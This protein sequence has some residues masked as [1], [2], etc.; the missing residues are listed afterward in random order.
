MDECWRHNRLTLRLCDL[1]ESA[2]RSTLLSAFGRIL[3]IACRL[4][5]A[6]SFIIHT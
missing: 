1:N 5:V 4:I 3:R 2:P 6:E